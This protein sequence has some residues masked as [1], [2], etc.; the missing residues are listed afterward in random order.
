MSTL[1][2]GV[3]QGDLH[4]VEV[5]LGGGAVGDQGLRP[6][7][8]DLGLLQGDLFGVEPRP[9]G[10]DLLGAGADAPGGGDLFEVGLHLRE[11]RLGLEELAG[12]VAGLER[13]QRLS[14]D[15]V[16]ALLHEDVLDAAPDPRSDLHGA[17]LDG[18]AP[19]DGQVG[20]VPLVHRKGDG[21]ASDQRAN[22][23]QRD[24]ASDHDRSPE[25]RF[26]G[27]MASPRA[28]TGRLPCGG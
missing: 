6:L 23:E 5:L 22:D 25:L 4:H 10:G 27:V 18:A 2:G 15:D 13:D 20:E 7:L 8:V 26:L 3:A 9:V 17:G 1:G 16:V 24:D 19:L 14:G 28:A 21:R 12:Q 11:L